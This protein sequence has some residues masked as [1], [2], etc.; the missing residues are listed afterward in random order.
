MTTKIIGGTIID[1][2]GS[3]AYQGEVLLRED[4]IAAMGPKLSESAKQ[5]VDAAGLV[6][7]PGFFDTHSHS[8]LKIIQEPF[9]PEK[10]SQGIT[11]EIV[12]QDGVCV[13]P[14]APEQAEAWK[15]ADEEIDGEA[16][17]EDWRFCATVKDYLER[18]E[19]AGPAGNFAYLTPHGNLRMAAIGLEARSASSQE[20]AR[21]ERQLAKTME[22]G[23][24]GLST[25]LIY[26]PC[27]FADRRELAGLCR[28]TAE[29]GGVFSVHQRSEAN[30]I[31]RSMEELLSIARE[32]GVRL[33]ISHFKICGRKNQGKL[34]KIIRLLDDARQAGL[35]VTL[36]QYP[37]IAGSTTLSMILP[38]WAQ[39]GGTEGVLRR[40]RDPETRARIREDI[41]AEGADWDNFVEFAGYDGITISR[42]HDPAGLGKTLAELGRLRN[43]DPLDAAFDL[44]V[45]NGG[46]VGMIDVYGSEDTLEALMKL[47]EQ[48]FCTDGVLG[49]SPHPRVWGSYPR[50]LGRYVRERK[51]LSQEDAV[52][53]MSGQAAF[54][55]GIRDRGLLKPG[56]FADLVLYD[57]NTVAET[58][59]FARPVRV[60]AGIRRVMVNGQTVL[61]DGVP[62][63]V[64]A[65]RVIRRG[66]LISLRE[67]LL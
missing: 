18:L 37:Y 2:T 15:S 44:I 54:A 9:M 59:T 21:M 58:A 30:D 17:W 61:T 26:P 7:C 47:P 29:L 63:E 42:A 67:Q 56:Y 24:L 34:P 14:I 43:C 35:T 65:G 64:S 51:V 19:L 8:G 25:G 3:P 12:G 13:A 46:G 33:H 60:C 28:V 27:S 40:L 52:R 50:I 32:T 1:G 22:E 10:L 57:P 16:P 20:C 6:V 48:N 5:V 23:S 41:L 66:D 49:E 62:A 11:T 39:D 38:P 55:M 45:K 31:L 53:R 36:D 4:K